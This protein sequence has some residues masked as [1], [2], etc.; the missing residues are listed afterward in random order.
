MALDIAWD[1]QSA[2]WR[3]FGSIDGFWP[4]TAASDIVKSFE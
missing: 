3:F 1:V 4:L 2:T